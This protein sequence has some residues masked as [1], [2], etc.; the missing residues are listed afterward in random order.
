MFTYEIGVAASYKYNEQSLRSWGCC[1]S[2]LSTEEGQQGLW[3]G[4]KSVVAI[5]LIMQSVNIRIL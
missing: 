5:L 3:L 1:H 4:R 2:S